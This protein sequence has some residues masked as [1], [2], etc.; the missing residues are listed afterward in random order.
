MQTC[1]DCGRK[2]ELP[3][4][5]VFGFTPTQ[6]YCPECADRRWQEA[7]KGGGDNSPDR[8][9]G[10][11]VNEALDEAGV[12]RRLRLQEFDLAPSIRGFMAKDWP[13]GSCGLYLSGETSTGKTTQAVEALRWALRRALERGRSPDVE[14][15]EMER[16]IRE[17]KPFGDGLERYGQADILVLDEMGR[18]THTD[19]T[20]KWI[21]AIIRERHGHCMPTLMTSNQ[22]LDE[23]VSHDSYDDR[24][25]R[26]LMDMTG[27][28][29]QI[30][31]MTEVYR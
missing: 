5:E 10:E 9:I 30:K 11:R 24:V 17:L 16:L 22:S 20:A 23:L 31:H 14:F 4:V 19:E 8:P 29:A 18:E 27:D 25:T 12:P 6:P 26:R 3:D 28:G 1:N 21:D 13:S 7:E 2:F 15:I